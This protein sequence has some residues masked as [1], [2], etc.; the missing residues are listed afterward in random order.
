MVARVQI[1]GAF[2]L[3]L[4]RFLG[5]RERSET[6]AREGDENQS[7]DE[8]KLGF[9]NNI[10]FLWEYWSSIIFEFRI[11]EKVK[12]KLKRGKFFFSP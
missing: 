8:R 4:P 7:M 1:N 6:R 10:Y 3:S 12:L 2:F 11:S 9:L 5:E